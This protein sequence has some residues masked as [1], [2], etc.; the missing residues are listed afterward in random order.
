MYRLLPVRRQVR[1]SSD[2][3]TAQLQAVAEE[4]R[5]S[6]AESDKQMDMGGLVAL[7]SANLS[8]ELLLRDCCFKWKK[9]G[10]LLHCIGFCRMKLTSYTSICV[11]YGTNY[12]TLDAAEDNSACVQTCCMANSPL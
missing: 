1:F 10:A 6:A 5:A 11:V 8:Q 12:A 9:G 4:A 3:T 7:G 2:T